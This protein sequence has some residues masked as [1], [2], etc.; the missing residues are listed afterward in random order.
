MNEILLEVRSS[1]LKDAFKKIQP[2]VLSNPVVMA[3][4]FAHVTVKGNTMT[5]KSTD[6]FSTIKV[7]KP[8]ISVD[9]PE[10]SS[11]LLPYSQVNKLL[12]VLPDSPITIQTIHVKKEKEYEDVYMIIIKCDADEFK[13]NSSNPDVYPNPVIKEDT[14]N[15]VVNAGPLA[16]A[17]DL[18]AITTQSDSTKFNPMMSGIYVG[19][20]N[21][22]LVVQSFGHI[23]ATQRVLPEDA[24]KDFTPFLL[25]Q[26]SASVL[27]KTCHENEQVS[28]Q[29]GK[30]SISVA[31]KD[32]AL[33]L[34][35]MEFKEYFPLKT[36]FEADRPIRI[37]I[38]S[39]SEFTTIL[40]RSLIAVN[41]MTSVA[42]FSIK[43]DLMIIDTF[44]LAT[45]EMT[46]SQTM[47]VECSEDIT[48]GMNAS[49][50]L[51]LISPHNGAMGI[52][53]V[54]H[55]SP[56]LLVFDQHD[57]LIKLMGPDGTFENIGLA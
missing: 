31:G 42:R 15:I 14:I 48:C 50:L 25:R 6:L 23:F 4:E 9:N 19:E 57:Y 2:A 24:P 26:D 10:K 1:D 18:C 53:A 55:K 22:K 44:D 51:K 28:M 45:K 36:V 39:I 21:G 37:H 7:Q 54:D 49:Y 40:K 30:S 3:L 27:A 38:P 5:V 47:N 32:T 56:F 46:S 17:L 41:G 16:E 20:L 11:F 43:G 13:F 34:T 33:K 52:H 29:V 12:G 35:L 8:V